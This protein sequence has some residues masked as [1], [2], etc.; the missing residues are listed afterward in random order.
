MRKHT[1]HCENWDSFKPRYLTD[2]RTGATLGV[3]MP[4]ATQAQLGP[5]IQ[6]WSRPATETRR[7]GE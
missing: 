6:S 1:I 4:R 3:L 7:P 5:G 2:I